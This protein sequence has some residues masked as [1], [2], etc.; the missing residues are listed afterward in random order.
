MPYKR[1]NIN[2]EDKLL[3]LR[4][5]YPEAGE[6]EKGLILKAVEQYKKEFGVDKQKTIWDD[7]IFGGKT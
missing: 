1:K 5:R 3:P 6:L 7:K 4:K 2:L